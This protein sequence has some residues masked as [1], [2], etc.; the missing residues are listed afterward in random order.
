MSIPTAA[1][2]AFVAIMYENGNRP[3]RDRDIA[4]M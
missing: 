2:I 1:S 3:T 4:T